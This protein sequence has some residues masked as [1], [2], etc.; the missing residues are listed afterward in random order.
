VRTKSEDLS[1]EKYIKEVIIME[2]KNLH[3]TRVNGT[4]NL[5]IYC[6]I[7]KAGKKKKKKKSMVNMI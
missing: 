2:E 1:G 5:P 4:S 7:I 6:R 3:V